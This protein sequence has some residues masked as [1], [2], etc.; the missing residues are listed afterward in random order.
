[1]NLRISLVALTVL[2]TSLGNVS[3]VASTAVSALQTTTYTLTASNGGG[4]TT[5][6]VTIVVA[7]QT[8]PPPSGDTQPPTPPNLTSAIAKGPTEVDLTW[9]GSMDNVGVTGYQILRNGAPV[10][11][12]SAATVLRRDGSEPE[13]G[14][15]LCDQSVRRGREFHVQ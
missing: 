12:V 13:Y 8:P 11:S 5:A 10:S 6:R 14:L 2:A 4:A 15:Q 1:M 9:T 7:A 3:S